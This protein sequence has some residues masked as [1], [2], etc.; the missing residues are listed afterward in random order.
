VRGEREGERREK[1]RDGE[2]EREKQCVCGYV[3]DF[4][5]H[6]GGQDKEGSAEAQLSSSSSS[7]SVPGDRAILKSVVQNILYVLQTLVD[8]HE[9]I[10]N[11]TPSIPKLNKERYTVQ[12]RS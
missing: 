6:G 9:R 11:Q 12:S 1:E 3:G 4:S 10:S 2:R 7:S 5:L 8:L